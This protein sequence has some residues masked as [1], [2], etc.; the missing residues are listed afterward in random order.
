[1]ARVYIGGTAAEH[2][3][4]I[5]V[6]TMDDATNVTAQKGRSGEIV[7]VEFDSSVQDDTLVILWAPA[8]AAIEGLKVL[9]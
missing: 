3:G 2:K 6:A 8:K 9:L 7:K 4:E 5:L 1:M